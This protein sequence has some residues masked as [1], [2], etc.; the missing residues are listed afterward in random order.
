MDEKKIN[1]QLLEMKKKNHL[2]NMI[3]VILLIVLLAVC[4]IAIY[5][6]VI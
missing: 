3:I 1:E 4:A 5:V 6:R 2:N